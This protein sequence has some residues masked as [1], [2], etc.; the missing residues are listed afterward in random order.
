MHLF[1]MVTIWT[2]VTASNLLESRTDD[3]TFLTAGYI[4]EF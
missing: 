2:T 4:G 1:L 3:G